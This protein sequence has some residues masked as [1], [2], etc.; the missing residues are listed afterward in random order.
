M[1]TATDKILKKII[2]ILL[3]LTVFNLYGIDSKKLSGK[4]VYEIFFSS[5]NGGGKM[6]ESFIFY[7]NKYFEYQLKSYYYSKKTG[8][9]NLFINY[10]GNYK[11]R[12]NYIFFSNLSK[13]GKTK[14]KMIKKWQ[15]ISYDNGKLKLKPVAPRKKGG[16]VKTFVRK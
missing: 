12:G 11:V 14:A 2:L 5:V 13:L 15:I 10:S 4:W 16:Y 6:Y 8:K 1:K 9:K 3:S 7:D